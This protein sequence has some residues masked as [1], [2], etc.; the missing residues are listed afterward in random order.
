MRHKIQEA[1]PD[2]FEGRDNSKIIVGDF[3]TSV[4]AIDKM[5]SQKISTDIKN[6]TNTVSQPDRSHCIPSDRRL[7]TN[8][9]G[10]YFKREIQ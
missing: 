3:N 4:S 1:N 5:T 8:T 10:H 7:K 6:F 2:T 9:A